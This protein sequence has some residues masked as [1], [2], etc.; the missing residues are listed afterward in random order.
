MCGV[1]LQVTVEHRARDNAAVVLF[2]LA[3]V[4]GRCV[5]IALSVLSKIS[6]TVI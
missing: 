4:M 5:T 1:T 6:S 3:Y 2:L